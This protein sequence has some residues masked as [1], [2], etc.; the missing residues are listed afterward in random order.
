MALHRTRVLLQQLCSG[1]RRSGKLGIDF[2]CCCLVYCTFRKKF[3]IAKL[4]NLDL[5]KGRFA[6]EY[7]F[8]SPDIMISCQMLTKAESCILAPCLLVVSKDAPRRSLRCVGTSAVAAIAD[9]QAQK[10]RVGFWADPRTIWM[11]RVTTSN[12]EK[13]I[14]QRI[15]TYDHHAWIH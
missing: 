7:P 12:A 6:L 13:P 4:S 8:V 15:M 10:R 9:P 11:H 14:Q 3:C 5:A 2:S 1:E